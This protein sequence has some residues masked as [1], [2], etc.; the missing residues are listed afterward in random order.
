MNSH[1]KFRE[2]VSRH[3]EALA[4][5]TRCRDAVG[6]AE[7][8]ADDATE[9]LARVVHLIF[10]NKRALYRGAE[11]YCASAGDLVIATSDVVIVAEEESQADP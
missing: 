11:Y 9:E 8:E 6:T 4:A 10:G 3:K 7:A 1:K 2:A 5:L